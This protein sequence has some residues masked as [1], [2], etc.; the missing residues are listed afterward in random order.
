MRKGA[1]VLV[2]ALAFLPVLADDRFEVALLQRVRLL[3]LLRFKLLEV[4]G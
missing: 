2:L 3:F 4:S 1:G